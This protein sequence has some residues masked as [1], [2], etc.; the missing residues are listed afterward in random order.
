MSEAGPP[1]TSAMRLPF[2]RVAGL[3]R[4]ARMSSLK[5]AATRFR[6][7]IATGSFSTRPRRQAGSQ[8]RSQ[9]R[10]RIPGK[11][12]GLPIDHVGV[13]VAACG[14]QADVFGNGRVRRAGP[15]AVDDL[16]EVVRAPNVGRFHLLLVRARLRHCC[17]AVS[18]SLRGSAS[19]VL[20]VS[21]SRIRGADT[22]RVG[23]RIS[24]A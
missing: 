21:R 8:G 11:H 10:P 7:Q 20:S 3:G 12:V 15:L 24:T 13:A 14:D 16:V 9:V 4:R 18:S 5:S 22:S 2:L 6:R 1:P 23:P 19:P 17:S